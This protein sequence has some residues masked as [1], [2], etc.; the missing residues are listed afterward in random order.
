MEDYPDLI[1]FY[2]KRLTEAGF[3]VEVE[4]DEVAG[5]NAALKKKPDLII[6]DISLP[7]T[8]DFD[9]IKLAK[10]SI[11]IAKIPI[12]VLTDLSAPADIKAGMDAGA[13][14]YF[15]RDDFTFAEVIDRI[16]EI[17]GKHGNI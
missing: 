6:F 12:V 4:N 13:S 10:S 9:F 3:D 15:V 11:K 2:R 14:E 16:K 5:M 8:D 17:I 7:E 1:P